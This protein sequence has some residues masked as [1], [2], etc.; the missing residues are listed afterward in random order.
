MQMRSQLLGHLADGRFHSGEALGNAL[1]VS[2]MA[3]WKHL[4][5]LREMGVDFEVVRGKGY[6][7]PET[8]EL[9]N[10]EAILASLSPQTRQDLGPLDVLL[11]VDS[12]N[13]WLR[14][15][16]QRGAGSGAVCLAEMQTAGRGRQ[17]R[18]WISPFAGHVCLSLLW[19]SSQGAAALGGLSL[20]AGIA[21]LRCLT[22]AG[23]RGA[24]LKWPNDVLVDGR[25]LAGILIDVE[26]EASGPCAAII[27]IGV[28][29]SLPDAAASVI[30]QPWTELSALQGAQQVSRNRLAGML[31]DSLFDV[32]A[33][34]D[35]QG[36]APFREEWQTHDVVA[37]REVSL[38]LPHTRIRGT[39]RGIDADGALL[40]ET[41][42]GQQQRYLSGEI[43]LRVTP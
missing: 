21:L 25:K 39:A 35:E 9:L 2:R 13:N 4:R 32:L 17:G 16:A 33:V 12:T 36:L 29:I 31:I 20:V 24:G 18:Q 6:R 14:L 28:N 27:G 19:R 30:D 42:G 34:F 8:C 40:I 15:Q 11:E 37:G 38:H 23:F 26:G 7:L 1:G 5:A 43:S 10:R 22:A 3:V 41:A